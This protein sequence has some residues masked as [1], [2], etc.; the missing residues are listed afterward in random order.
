MP[1][2]IRAG[3]PDIPAPSI[4]SIES[5]DESG[6]FILDPEQVVDELPQPF[7][8]IDRTLCRLL[9]ETWD[10]I[11]ERAEARAKEA[12]RVRPP[13][14]S[15]TRSVTEFADSTAM[16]H[17]SDVRYLFVGFES[18]ELAAFDAVTYNKI[19]EWSIKEYSANVEFIRCVVIGPQ[20]HVITM[21]D[22]MGFA[23]LLAFANETFYPIQ[24][25]NEQG[26]GLPKTNAVKFT[27]SQN[28]D[29]CGLALECDGTS[30]LEVYKLPRDNWLSEIDIAQKNAL[31]KAQASSETLPESGEENLT[32]AASEVFEVKFSPII[33]VLKVKSPTP[34]VPNNFSSVQEATEQ[35]G[36][37]NTIGRGNN[38]LLTANHLKI[39]EAI[40]HKLHEEQMKYYKPDTIS[41]NIPT[42]HYLYASRMQPDTYPPN[43]ALATMPV[44]VCVWW[45]DSYLL[46]IFPLQ[47]KGGKD[48]EL[49]PE[50]VWPMTGRIS[51]TTVSDCTNIMAVGLE[52]GHVT[53]I[54]RHLCIPRALVSVGAKLPVIDMHILDG[55]VKHTAP[56]LVNPPP[57]NI[58]VQLENGSVHLLDCNSQSCKV[59]VPQSDDSPHI[60][61]V[62]NF[63]QILFLATLG[64]NAHL[65][66]TLTGNVICDVVMS[67]SLEPP[68]RRFMFSCDGD[69]L[70]AKNEDGS[71]DEF[72]LQ[73]FTSLSKLREKQS[74]KQS[75]TFTETVEER[76]ERLL[77][78]R[79]KN[80]RKRNEVLAARWKVMN[81]ELEVLIS[82]K[83]KSKT[84][85]TSTSTPSKWSQT[86]EKL[87]AH[88]RALTR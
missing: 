37:P 17:S 35:A 84:P 41:S 56:Q 33:L 78:E 54:D 59:L 48:I 58:M 63:P 75:L 71:M 69:I 72:H 62:P 19:S 12:R 43:S 86:T 25:L 22:D 29:F 77:Q 40:T 45:K 39:R 74:V 38:H 31:K 53:V 79:T 10:K 87:L 70:Y 55:S 88:S 68:N 57:L 16:C 18:G 21:I 82:L 4:S 15:A 60:S 46:Q 7:R 20:I 5:D 67:Q 36:L 3:E 65:H 76:C 14:H 24:L 27:I 6:V 51:C 11:V 28:G 83:A 13:L 85:R 44:S 64:G 42:W 66:E 50:L 73:N 80:Q 52:T 26:E 49:K 81:R 32:P 1:V 61:M 9:D 8:M 23:R 34:L 2:Y 30:W 47:A